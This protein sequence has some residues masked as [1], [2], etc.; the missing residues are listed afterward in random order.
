MTPPTDTSRTAPV[1]VEAAQAKIGAR[2]RIGAFYRTR[3]VTIA[4]VVF[5]VILLVWPL[6]YKNLYYM[7]VMT[8]A[9][10]FAMLAIAVGLILGQAGQLSFG[11]SAFYG[12][13][14][15]AAALLS[16]KLHV[17]TLAALA[18]AAVAPGIIALIIGRPVLKLRYF[19]LALAT[20]GLGQIFSVLIIQLPSVTRGINGLNGI[21]TLSIFGFGVGSLIRQYYVVWVPA[22]LV[23]LLVQ[24]GLKYRLGRS[25]RAIAT[26]EIASSTLG[27]RPANWKL[28]AFVASAVVCGLA[29]GLFA[30]VTGS[31]APT[32]FT[33]NVAVLPIVMSL[34][35]G[36]AT[37]WG[38]VLGAIIMTWVITYFTG[39]QQYSGV[40]YSVIM[41]LLLL[42]LPMGILGI[43]PASRSWL[44]RRIKGELVKDAAGTVRDQG[45]AS[46]VTETMDL[47]STSRP[48]ASQVAAVAT[49]PIGSGLLQADLAREKSEKRVVGPLLSIERASIVFGGLKAVNEVSFDVQEGTI[50]ALIGPNGAGKTTLFNAI[51]RLQRLTGGRITFEGNDLTKLSPANAARL[52]MARTFQNLRIFVNMSVL[53]NVLV[54]CHRHERSGFWSCCLGF[55]RQRAEERSSRARAMEALALVGL[56]EEATKPA[57]SLPYGQQRLVEIARALASEP[58]LLMLDEP[59]AGMNASERSDLVRKIA[60]IRAAGITVLLVEHDISLVMGISDSVNVLDYGK[61]I[62]SGAPDAVR[63]DEGVITAYLGKGRDKETEVC[64][65][66]NGAEEPCAPPEDALVLKDVVTAYGSIQALRG[67]SL[68]VAK[69]EVVAVL[70][71]NGAGKTTLLETVC[72]ILRPTSGT[73]TYLGQDI[74]SM[75]AEKIVT[76]G[77]CQIPEGRQL[78]PT[79]TAED[80]LLMGASGKREWQKGY[81]DDLAYVYELFPILSER[82]RQLAKTLSGGEQQMLAIGRGLMAQPSLLLLDEP[83]MG[84]APIAVERIFD[85]LARLNSQG[86]TM[87]MVEQNAEMALSLAGRVTVIQTGS[88]VLSGKSSDLGKDDRLRA[89]YLGGR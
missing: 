66:E 17:P 18:I 61:L 65:A 55:P 72:G 68:S 70:G 16:L 22:L 82:R 33:F 43:H 37:I 12:M 80:N 74:T 59:A 89:A 49:A 62:A 67:V 76:H 23:L 14:A 88:V 26:S 40:A 85:A 69:G 30:F 34:V 31:I 71:A 3:Y 39:I 5:V 46:T 56:V 47:P 78:F 4:K 19:Y 81:A 64:V 60:A 6:A 73:V 20:I 9:G 2:D 77:I 13:G 75:P 15:Y 87:L 28:L 21:P 36:A 44:R 11:H 42:F 41:I 7:S 8:T 83:S 53:E 58:R 25:L 50:T 35:G 48:S 1:A 10:L 57:V 54:G 24:R 38:G 63:R 86:L 84:L 32:S 45:A 52:G 29:G 51:S 27:I 79:L